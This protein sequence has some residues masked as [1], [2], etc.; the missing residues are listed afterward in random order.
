MKAEKFEFPSGVRFGSS[1]PKGKTMTTQTNVDGASIQSIVILLERIAIALEKLAD[2]KADKTTQVE[3]EPMTDYERYIK[4]RKWAEENGL[5]DV[6]ACKSVGW[7]HI[8]SFDKISR[9][10]LREVRNCGEKTIQLILD[11][12][13]SKSR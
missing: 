6:R 9:T 8:D 7:A 12:A 13:E 3:L 1:S 5:E 10:A 4:C 2:V 11:W